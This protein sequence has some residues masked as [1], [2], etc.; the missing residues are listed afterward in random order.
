[1]IE[2]RGTEEGAVEHPQCDCSWKRYFRRP[3]LARNSKTTVTRTINNET[4]AC[5]S[6]AQHTLKIPSRNQFDLLI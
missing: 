2:P 4:G 3:N 1:M 5:Q 6:I